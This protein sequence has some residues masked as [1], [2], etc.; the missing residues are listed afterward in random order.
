M[1][2]NKPPDKP[3]TAAH[4]ASLQSFMAA[5]GCL[6]SDIITATGAAPGLNRIQVALN[7]R[8]LLKK[9]KKA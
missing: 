2:N 4:H 5:K 1:P 3:N 8:E 7:I 6:A 9:S